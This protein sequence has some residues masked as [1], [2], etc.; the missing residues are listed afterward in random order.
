MVLGPQDSTT[1]AAMAREA[2]EIGGRQSEKTCL[3]GLSIYNFGATVDEQKILE[4]AR[5]SGPGLK[6]LFCRAGLR[7]YRTV[8]SDGDLAE[9]IKSELM[10][11]DANLRFPCDVKTCPEVKS[12]D[13]LC[14]HV[15]LISDWDTVYG[16]YLAETVKE[17][18]EPKDKGNRPDR[19][20]MT[21]FSYLRGLDGRLPNRR[22]AG[23]QTPPRSTDPGQQ[24]TEQAAATQP[25]AATPETASRFESAEGQS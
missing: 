19:A 5:A 2:R 17:T 11:R 3:D 1:L 25:T 10:Q 18:F 21:T 14:D 8:N 20:W 9:T 7:Y 12:G 16:Y 13:G 15:V 4:A 24:P 22:D 6:E 23:Q